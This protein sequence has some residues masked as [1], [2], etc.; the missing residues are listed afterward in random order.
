MVELKSINALKSNFP[1]KI[2]GISVCEVQSS[3]ITVGIGKKIPM[4]LAREIKSVS[5]MA[6][7]RCASYF[8]GMT[9]T[10]LPVKMITLN[11]IL[12]SLNRSRKMNGK[13]IQV[14]F[15][16]P[17][18]VYTGGYTGYTASPLVVVALGQ[19]T[20]CVGQIFIY[21]LVVRCMIGAT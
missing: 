1:L 20:V 14:L 21:I 6:P 10:N 7:V 4:P 12:P 8:T 15:L 16:A 11:G 19:R 17:H 3:L 5:G 18:V 9:T 2:G 13:G